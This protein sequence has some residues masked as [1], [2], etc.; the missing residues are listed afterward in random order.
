MYIEDCT[1]YD[2]HTEKPEILHALVSVYGESLEDLDFFDEIHSWT[3]I[4]WKAL[5][6]YLDKTQSLGIDFCIAQAATEEGLNVP[7]Q[8]PA[9]LV[10]L[11]NRACRTLNERDLKGLQSVLA[12]NLGES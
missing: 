8:L 10:Y 1:S 2:P 7:E 12:Y 4:F 3:R 6:L 5:T 9:D 11:I